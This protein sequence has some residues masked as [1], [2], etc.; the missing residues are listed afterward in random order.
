MRNNIFLQILSYLM[1]V[2]FYESSNFFRLRVNNHIPVIS[3]GNVDAERKIDS[4]HFSSTFGNIIV[5]ETGSKITLL[6]PMEINTHILGLG[7][8]AFGIDRRRHKFSSLNKDPGGYE[9]G[10][11]PI[12]LPI[13]FF[14]AV[15]EGSA[16]GIFINY[17]G[18]IN[19]DFGVETYNSIVAEIDSCDAEIFVFKSSSVK[20]I[21]RAFIQLTGKPCVPPKWAIGHA[22]S[23]YTYYPWS[24][25]REVLN[26]YKE[27]T[28]VD[29]IYLD[30][31]FMDGYRLFTW[32]FDRFGDGKIFLED[33]HKQDAKV[34]TIIDPSIKVD[35][36]FDLFSEGIGHY[37]ETPNGDIYVGP[38]WPGLSAFPDFFNTDSR[39]YWKSRVKKWVRQGVD[40]IWLDMNEPT[41]LDE[42]LMMDPNALHRLDNGEKIAHRKV[43]N[44]YPYLENQA[45][46][47][48]MLE[49]TPE[50]FILTRSGYAGIQKYA[51]VWSGDNK[52]TWDDV[53]LQI[54]VVTSMSISGITTVGCDVGGF[55]GNSSP[56]L[57][58]AY[59]R[60]ALLFPIYRNHNDKRSNDQEVFLL[61][62][63]VKKEV[64]ETID[65][66]YKFLDHIYSLLQRSHEE[67]IPVVSPL[68]YLYRD[69]DSFYA[70]DEYLLGENILYAPQIYKD[71]E[72]RNVYLPHGEWI[73]FWTGEYTKGPKY[74]S[75][76]EKYPIY[77]QNNSVV[78]Y[79]K[80]IIVYGSGE[81]TV[82]LGKNVRIVSDGDRVSMEPEVQ[83]Y[84]LETGKLVR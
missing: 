6:I 49:V 82:Y 79:D 28:H 29:S 44:A 8:R 40:G 38:M 48:A 10:D 24:Q 16:I 9:N 4:S 21:V 63:N 41:I 55:V 67:C 72:S 23:K 7:E 77:V 81:F 15:H 46:Y 54:S 73:N 65:L 3:Y 31:H 60:M 59:Y 36:H 35:Q 13:P 27:I 58:Q 83:G 57:I 14:I 75:T 69:D 66:R 22:I 17:P 64:V 68:P 26:R 70:D 25:V 51:A 84:T 12:Y 42:T 11:D 80:K 45:T 19:F 74:A 2:D 56:E 62:S 78:L 1:N 5:K 50:P 37:V 71:K 47:E 34:V 30:I 20:D 39:E 76:R 32:D 61:P 53:R 52:S 43:R 18:E 33:I